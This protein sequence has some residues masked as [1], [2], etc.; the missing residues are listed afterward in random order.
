M[1]GLHTKFI[2]QSTAAGDVDFVRR[3]SWDRLKKHA[4]YN[5]VLL[6][7]P[8]SVVEHLTFN[9]GVPGSIPGG[10]TSLRL[11][12]EP[13]GEGYGWQASECP[14]RNGER[15]YGSQARRLDAPYVPIV[16]RPRTRPF[17]G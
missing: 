1:S 3:V 7:A 10:P 6:R 2:D 15:G 13:V 11:A 9:Q 16:Q 14:A 4:W 12:R 17:Q 8:S 5:A